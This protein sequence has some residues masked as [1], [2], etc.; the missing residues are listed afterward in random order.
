LVLACPEHRLES[1]LPGVQ[2]S[3]VLACPEH[4]LESHLPGVQVSRVLACFLRV[5]TRNSYAWS[6]DEIGSGMS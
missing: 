4:R 6:S 1:P 5:E 2:V 3:L